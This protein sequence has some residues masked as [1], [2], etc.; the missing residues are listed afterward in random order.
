MR[1]GRFRV[2][3]RFWIILSLPFLIIYGYF[4]VQEEAAILAQ[5]EEI[6]RLNL[7]IESSTQ[8]NE[9][10]RRKIEFVQTP[11]YVEQAARQELGL[12]KEGE[13][14]FVPSDEVVTTEA[15]PDETAE[16]EES[17]EVSEE[18]EESTEEAENEEN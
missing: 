7:Q 2:R 4:L 11:D 17:D 18:D 8:A 9:D 15:P 14:R 10:L 16:E 5:E 1:L 6:Q 13:I 12:L 3:K